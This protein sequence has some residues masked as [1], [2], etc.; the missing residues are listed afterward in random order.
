MEPHSETFYDAYQH[1]GSSEIAEIVRSELERSSAESPDLK[2]T[3]ES[4]FKLATQFVKV[5]NGEKG[6][7]TL[8]E[9]LIG[10][11]KFS[12]GALV[13]SGVIAVG[14]GGAA[15]AVIAVTGLLVS[16][17][18]PE[19]EKPDTH[20]VALSNM[21]TVLLN[22]VDELKNKL[23][24]NEINKSL[25]KLDEAEGKLAHVDTNLRA[26]YKVVLEETTVEDFKR[27]IEEKAREWDWTDTLDKL[28]EAKDKILALQKNIERL[29]TSGIERAKL[30]LL[31]YSSSYKCLVKSN[32]T[33]ILAEKNKENTQKCR[34]VLEA[35]LSLAQELRNSFDNFFFEDE[36]FMVLH[37]TRYSFS[38]V[39]HSSLVNFRDI[40]RCPK[41]W[42][43]WGFA[44]K[45]KP[46]SDD[47]LDDLGDDKAFDLV[48]VRVPYLN[49][50][51]KET[52]KAYNATYIPLKWD[53]EIES[54]FRT[55]RICPGPDGKF[56]MED[57]SHTHSGKSWIIGYTIVY[58][59]INN[60]IREKWM[61]P[62]EGQELRG[63]EGHSIY[64]EFGHPSDITSKGFVQFP[65]GEDVK[66][67]LFRMNAYGRFLIGAREDWHRCNSTEWTLE[68]SK[69]IN[70]TAK[71]VPVLEVN[72]LDTKTELISYGEGNFAPI[73]TLYDRVESWS[74]KDSTGKLGPKDE[75]V[76]LE[77]HLLPKG[78]REPKND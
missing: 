9:P 53:S 52:V 27:V 1:E 43:D 62:M 50:A 22:A 63:K 19:G 42:T 58:E 4:G 40:F 3:I 36:E 29:N 32:V 8:A 14:T 55:V 59:S 73:H 7:E 15:F 64:T 20:M 39:E 31:F 41:K 76:K 70:G 23:E 18:C 54:R 60:N 56:E 13:S 21:Q 57:L 33:F 5:Q 24:Q 67:K 48:S 38:D 44:I 11:A 71:V 77:W 74:F 49:D 45:T 34:E 68:V 12:I 10:F 17:G 61:D 26:F 51:D 2:D 65:K 46:G 72:M 28:S 35:I 30:I 75:K 37:R 69:G 6:V 16:L 78:W 66:K 25:G 47:E